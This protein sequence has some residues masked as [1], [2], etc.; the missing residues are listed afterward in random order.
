MI[1]KSGLSKLWYKSGMEIKTPKAYAYLSFNCPE[2]NSSPEATILTYIFTW[3]LADEM[4]EYGMFHS[5]SH[6]D[7]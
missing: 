4:T 7:R 1:R 6:L 3:L 5:T 2:S